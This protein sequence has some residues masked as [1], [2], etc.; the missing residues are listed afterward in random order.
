MSNFKRRLLSEWCRKSEQLSTRSFCCWNLTYSDREHNGQQ[1]SAAAVVVKRY[2]QKSHSSATFMQ[3][4][5][6]VEKSIYLQWKYFSRREQKLKRRWT[7]SMAA[8]HMKK[9]FPRGECR[10]HRVANWTSVVP[11]NDWN[12]PFSLRLGCSLLPEPALCQFSAA[13]AYAG[14]QARAEAVLHAAERPRFPKIT[15]QH[16]HI[17]IYIIN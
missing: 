1:N 7:Q 14:L 10:C 16:S 3:L 12:E 13:G 9:Q 15:I 11:V 8:A 6:L 2:Y 5:K 4:I 17:N